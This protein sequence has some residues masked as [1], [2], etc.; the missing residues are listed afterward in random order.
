MHRTST[1]AILFIPLSDTTMRRS[2]FRHGMNL[3]LYTLHSIY[4]DEKQITHP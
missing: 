4:F 2:S 1:S 3:I